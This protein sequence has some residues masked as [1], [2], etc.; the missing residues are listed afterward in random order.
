MCAGMAS[1]R[2]EMI[3]PTARV[4]RHSDSCVSFAVAVSAGVYMK[5]CFFW[6]SGRDTC[7]FLFLVAFLL[8]W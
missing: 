1:A 3:T 6:C 5:S 8:A 4:R 2:C 7:F